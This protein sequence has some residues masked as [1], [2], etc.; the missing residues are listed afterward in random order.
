MQ[1]EKP[2]NTDFFGA[3]RP[4]VSQELARK[5]SGAGSNRRHRPFQGRALPTE[6]PDQG[7]A[8]LPF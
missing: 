8:M 7:T 3:S 5:W 1:A 2:Q 6:L 4:E